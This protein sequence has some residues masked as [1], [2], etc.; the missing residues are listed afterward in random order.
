MNN[1]TISFFANL[2]AKLVKTL[3]EA[4][5]GKQE[6]ARA[7]LVSWRNGYVQKR[8]DRIRRFE[9]LRSVDSLCKTQ[10]KADRCKVEPNAD[11]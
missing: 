4:L 2:I 9:L 7:R 8:N 1:S 3:V 10:S 5:L 11:K 6:D